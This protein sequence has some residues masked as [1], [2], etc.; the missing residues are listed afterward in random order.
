MTPRNWVEVSEQIVQQNP[1]RRLLDNRAG[2]LR[3]Q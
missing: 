1:A 3:M 2:A